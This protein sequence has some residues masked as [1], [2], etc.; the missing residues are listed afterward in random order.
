MVTVAQVDLGTIC[1]DEDDMVVQE[2]D[3]V[4]RECVLQR[5]PVYIALPT[6][7]V[8]LPVDTA[9][10][11]SPINTLPAVTPESERAEEE[12]LA[13]LL[14][15]ISH[16]TQPL[17]I[18]DGFVARWSIF[19]EIDTLVRLLRWPTTS[20]PFGKSC[21]DETLPN[22]HGIYA[23]IAGRSVYKPW[24]DACDLVLRFGGLDSDVN[25]YGFSTL[26]P[27]RATDGALPPTHLGYPRAELA[28]LPPP[29]PDAG[30]EQHDFWRRISNF[31][32]EGDVILTETGTPSVG[33]RE[34]VLP[35]NARLINS[36]IWLSI[37]FMM[38]AACGA[39]LGVREILQQERKDEGVNGESS[40]R[41]QGDGQNGLQR[42]G[43]SD[44]TSALNDPPQKNVLSSTTASGRT[45]L[46]EGDGSFQ[47]TAQE[48]STVIWHKLDLTLFLINND[49]YTI[50]RFIHGMKAHYNDV[51]RWRY[52][53][54]P[55][56]FGADMTGEGE[57]RE[58]EGIEAGTSAGDG[59]VVVNGTVNGDGGDEG[60]LDVETGAEIKGHARK[61]KQTTQAQGRRHGQEYKI[62]TYQA[63]TWGDLLSI[64]D[65]EEVKSGKGLCMIEVFMDREDAP[66]SL[67]RL[68][69]NV[70]RRNSGQSEGDEWAKSEG[71]VVEEKII[72]AAG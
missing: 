13:R 72:K 11:A 37:G 6:D 49:G 52:L 60:V 23:G 34:F 36:S 62:Q 14:S 20:T 45:I 5:R 38:A 32:K 41:E 70:V 4:L 30:I 24:V 48:L 66:E 43:E 25:T 51:S 39:A 68:V 28:S 9:R 18:I 55:Y 58:W 57:E 15:R 53:D 33:S 61:G 46:F 47:M 44:L 42:N 31:F 59:E 67:K 27:E 29:D 1:G 10:L 40:H 17:L 7:L 8:D 19:S 54:A 69:A 26:P 3:R 35:R 71:K 2:I 22:F 56:F 12:V 65:R 64:L 50:E 63:R 16:A 21:V